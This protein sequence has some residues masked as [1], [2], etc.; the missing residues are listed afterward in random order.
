MSEASASSKVVSLSEAIATSC[1]PADSWPSKSSLADWSARRPTRGCGIK[2]M[3]AER[4]PILACGNKP[5]LRGPMM[6]RLPT[7]KRRDERSGPVSALLG[8]GWPAELSAASSSADQIVARLSAA[9]AERPMRGAIRYWRFGGPNSLEGSAELAAPESGS[10]VANWRQS[11]VV[12]G[13]SVQKCR[14]ECEYKCGCGC[15]CGCG[16]RCNLGK[17][18]RGT[19]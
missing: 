11:A 6:R 3:G 14:C 13:A 10:Q 19:S 7:R 12:L 2:P 1:W 9:P 17:G 18:A 5:P 4:R 15:G 8:C 16:C